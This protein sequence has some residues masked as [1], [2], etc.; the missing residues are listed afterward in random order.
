MTITKQIEI[1][2]WEYAGGFAENKDVAR[3]IR[4]NHIL[5]ALKYGDQVILNYSGVETTTQSFTHAL[6]SDVIRE[7]RD[8]FFDRVV[9]K[10]CSLTVQRIITIVTEYMQKNIAST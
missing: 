2:I 4:E 6:I 1:K 7:Y 10:Q 3:D 5:K 9:F 8:D